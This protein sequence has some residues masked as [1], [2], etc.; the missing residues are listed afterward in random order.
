MVVENEVF[1]L[2]A[3]EDIL[4]S[5]GLVS[6]GARSGKDGVTIFQKHHQNIDLVILDLHL[7]GMNGVEVLKSLREIKPDIKVIISSGYDE[8]DI[9][10][11]LGDQPPA[12]ILK[13]PY[14]AQT[15]LDR[16]EDE[17]NRNND[18]LHG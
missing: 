9:I 10:R 8:R 15:L 1:V 12:T 3:L 7:P 4:G 2:E 13:K 17:L 5:A 16:V 6:I 11:Q 14:N 18:T